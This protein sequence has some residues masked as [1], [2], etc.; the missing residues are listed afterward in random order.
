LTTPEAK[1]KRKFMGDGEVSFDGSDGEGVNNERPAKRN[2]KAGV[3]EK[4]N[5]GDTS[6]DRFVEGMVARQKSQAEV[7]AQ[8]LKLE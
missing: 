2:R 7:D 8:Q 3:K 4:S 6:F 1:R 5:S